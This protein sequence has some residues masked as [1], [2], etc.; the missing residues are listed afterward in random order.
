MLREKNL[1]DYYNLL[2]YVIDEWEHEIDNYN[3]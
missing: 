1:T 3:Y 2:E